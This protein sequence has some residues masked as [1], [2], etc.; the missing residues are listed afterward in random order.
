MQT[1]GIR[2]LV[3]MALAGSA[4]AAQTT[5]NFNFSV[6]GTGSFVYDD[7]SKTTSAITFDFG[8]LGSI[9]PYSFDASLTARVFGTPPTAAI[10]RTA[11][12]SAPRGWPGISGPRFASTRTGPTA[13]A[14]IP[15]RGR[16]IAS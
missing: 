14:P 4:N 16:T 5:Y 6:G 8:S 9:A 11:P 3:F 10:H 12:F 7:V 13:C 15:S 1:M 2:L